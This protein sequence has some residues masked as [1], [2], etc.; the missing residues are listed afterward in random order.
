LL[1][2]VSYNEANHAKSSRYLVE[3]IREAKFLINER[4]LVCEVNHNQAEEY[5]PQLELQDVDLRL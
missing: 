1:L 2:E 3:L 5:H 4:E